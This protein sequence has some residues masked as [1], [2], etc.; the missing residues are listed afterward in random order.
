MI[1]RHCRRSA[2]TNAERVGAKLVGPLS[3][4]P[5]VMVSVTATLGPDTA[6]HHH[7]EGRPS[8]GFLGRGDL[9]GRMNISD[10]DG[11]RRQ[12]ARTSARANFPTRVIAWIVVH[13]HGVVVTAEDGARRPWP[14][15]TTAVRQPFTSSD[16]GSSSLGTYCSCRFPARYAGN[17]SPAILIRLNRHTWGAP[18]CAA[19]AERAGGRARRRVPAY[20]MRAALSNA[21]S[22]P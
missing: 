6:S 9:E 20:V 19:C 14:A 4:R 3:C 7:T 17:G 22:A 15:S 8:A 10:T 18:M 13:Q 11:A 16:S 1:S 2:S 5:L 12:R 21:G